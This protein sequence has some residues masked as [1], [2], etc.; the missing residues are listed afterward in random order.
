M[1]IDSIRHILLWCT[2]INY[3]VLLVWFLVF[4]FAHN[5]MYRLHGRLFCLTTE[6]F[7][8]IHYAAMAVYK[9]VILLFNLV[10][11]IA[12]HIG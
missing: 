6:Q 10:P 3:C 8:T 1:N 4:I 11:Y 2:V 7:D 5:W 12:L 9:I